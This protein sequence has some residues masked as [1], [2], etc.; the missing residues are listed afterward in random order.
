M[1]ASAL[2]GQKV[3]IT[4]EMIAAVARFIEDR[5]ELIPGPTTN[6][7]AADIIQVALEARLA[8]PETPSLCREADYGE[9][10]SGGRTP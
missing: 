2:H 8:K 9:S 4:P 6:H 1:V 7:L 5:F 10:K 3:E